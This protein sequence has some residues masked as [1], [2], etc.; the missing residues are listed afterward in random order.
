MRFSSQTLQCLNV[1]QLTNRLGFAFLS[2][3]DPEFFG[4]PGQAVSD[5]AM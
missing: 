2:D 4:V 1:D 3:H 5:G